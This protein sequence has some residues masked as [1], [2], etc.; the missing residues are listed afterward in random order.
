MG[1]EKENL[2]RCD[3]KVGG[4]AVTMEVITLPFSHFAIFLPRFHGRKKGLSLS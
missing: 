1:G 4:A 3:V 2:Y